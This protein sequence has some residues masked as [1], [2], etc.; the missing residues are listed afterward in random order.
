MPATKADLMELAAETK[1]DIQRLEAATK[2][3]MAG[4]ATRMDSQTSDIKRL[5]ERTLRMTSAV[6]S[7]RAPSGRPPRAAISGPA[8]LQTPPKELHTVTRPR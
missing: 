2:S 1:A 7:P 5:D 3:D 6:S 4:L 8:L